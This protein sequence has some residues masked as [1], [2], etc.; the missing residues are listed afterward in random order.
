[1]TKKEFFQ[2]EA[3]KSSNQR[4][5][6]VVVRTGELDAA[7]GACIVICAKKN[8]REYCY[9][10]VESEHE[11]NIN[12]VVAGCCFHRRFFFAN[13]EPY[14]IKTALQ[15]GYVDEIDIELWSKIE[16]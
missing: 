3:M 12:V 11:F 10:S 5:D 14:D 7:E 13:F 15:E 8:Q 6:F 16:H 2:I 9:L 4:E 1:M